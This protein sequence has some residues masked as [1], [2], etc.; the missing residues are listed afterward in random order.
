[1]IDPDRGC[2]QVKVVGE[3]LPTEAADD[4]VPMDQDFL[5]TE[6]SNG[7]LL[8]D[9]SD[10]HSKTDPGNKEEGEDLNAMKGH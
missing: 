4:N 5:V 10:K 7:P 8:G 3:T 1:M 2:S 6:R 9:K